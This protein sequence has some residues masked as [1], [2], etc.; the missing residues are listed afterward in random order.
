MRQLQQCPSNPCSLLIDTRCL[1]PQPVHSNH[2]VYR[3]GRPVYY[4]VY[5]SVYYTL[6]RKCILLPSFHMSVWMVSPGNTGLE[7][8]ALMD[9]ILDTSSPQYSLRTCRVAMPYEQS[10]CRIG[11]WK[12]EGSTEVTPSHNYPLKPLGG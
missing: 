2:S 8:R 7:K 12:P 4:S 1:S 5:Q 10:P 3:A 9:F 11:V 6:Q